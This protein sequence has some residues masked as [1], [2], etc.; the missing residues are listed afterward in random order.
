MSPGRP[1][2]TLLALLCAIAA[3][4][5]PRAAADVPV[6]TIIA[7]FEDDS[8]AATLGDLQNVLPTDCT[9]RRC[10]IPARGQYSLALDFGATAPNV[11]V[12]CNLRL[13]EPRRFARAD[14]IGAFYWVKEGEFQLAFRVRDA[15][16]QIFET[17]PQSLTTRDRWVYV[18]ADL[19][20]DKLHRLKGSGSLT[21]PIEVSG[22]RAASR[23]LGRQSVFIDD[24][25]V[26]HRV[27]TREI[28][29]GE[30]R[31]D[32]PTRI[33]EPGSKVAAAVVLENLSRK[34]ALPLSVE[35]AWT[36]PDGSVL[37]T[38]Q[39]SRTLPASG[40][41]FRSRQAIDFSQ[42]KIGRA[43]CRERVSPSV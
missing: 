38:Q 19:N 10:P 35:L 27:D 34:T 8:L 12:A 22:F 17:E 4:P 23:Q 33:Y 25:Q 11:S 32:E 24:V 18:A 36:R 9:V 42:V 26:E 13:R 39:A 16:G 30:F 7:D 6:I 20:P 5:G 43:S 28:V 3:Y 14:R 15:G 29:Q 1:A 2:A 37:Q 41:D 31:F 21:W 40:A